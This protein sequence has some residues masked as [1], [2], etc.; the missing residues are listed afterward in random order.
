MGSMPSERRFDVDTVCI[1][2]AGPSGLAAAKYLTAERAFSRITVFEQRGN[3]GG[4][5]NYVPLASITAEDLVVPQ[6][7]AR[8]GGEDPVWKQR[9]ASTA[10]SNREQKGKEFLTPIYDRLE[11]NLPRGLMGFSELDWP[12]DCQLLPEHEEVLKYLERYARDVWH[13]I[14]FNTQVLDVRFVEG[15]EWTVKVQ[16]VSQDRMGGVQ[17]HHFDAVV[18]ANGHFNVPYIPDVLGMGAW[19]RAFPGTITHSKYYRKPEHYAGKKVVVVG[20]SASGIDIGNQ[21][22]AVCRSPLLMSQKTESFLTPD[23]SPDLVEK[24]PISEYM[25]SSRS[26]R[27]EDGSIEAD[28]DAFV[29]CTG[30]FYSY[31]FLDTLEP[32]LITTGERVENLYQHIFYRPRPTLAFPVLNQKVIP[33]PVAEVQSAV[34]ARVF[35]GRLPIPSEEEME[36]WE[37]ETVK[38]KGSG[39]GFHVLK[40]PEDA[41]YINMLHDWAISA[42]S[43]PVKRQGTDALC[44]RADGDCGK[45]PPRWGEREFW[46]RERFPAI[47]KAFQS[48]GEER[49]SKKSLEDIGYDFDAWKRAKAEEGKRLW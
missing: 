4:I 18:V 8:R 42:D 30:Y 6:T 40:F 13:L 15:E 45:E 34:I 25:A 29:Y 48:L 22:R 38:Q 23:P 36:E 31:P 26:V 7:N 32:P 11:S 35:A 43:P 44:K 3:V 21:I 47:K 12:E 33:F 2:G 1:I 20:N 41:E 9:N 46:M 19:A 28:V 17:T 5:W 37:R 10:L 24:P 16:E 39:R 49:H 27:F 14:Q